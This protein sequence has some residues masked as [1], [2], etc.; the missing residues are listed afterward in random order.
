MLWFRKCILYTCHYETQNSKCECMTYIVLFTW[1]KSTPPQC[2]DIQILFIPTRDWWLFRLNQAVCQYLPTCIST[3]ADLC[4]PIMLKRSLGL[5]NNHGY[6]GTAPP[7]W[8]GD[9]YATDLNI[10]PMHSYT[11]TCECVHALNAGIHVHCIWA[12]KNWRSGFCNYRHTE[13]G[14]ASMPVTIFGWKTR[15]HFCIP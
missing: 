12:D 15:S 1:D 10:L 11:C 3:T 8:D 13:H 4:A 6:A 7:T 14:W 9:C 2:Q 5:P